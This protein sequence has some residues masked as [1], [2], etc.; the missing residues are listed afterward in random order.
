MGKK[1]VLNDSTRPPRRRLTLPNALAVACGIVLWLALIC[2]YAGPMTAA[3]IDCL[4]V[5]GGVVLLWLV[6]AVG[7]GS[8]ILP[9][10]LKSDAAPSNPLLRF[11]TAAAL[12]LGLMGLLVL[13]LGLAGVLNQIAAFIVIALAALA[14][15]VKLWRTPTALQALRQWFREPAGWRWLLLLAVPLVAV[16]TLGNL[17]PPYVLWNP[18]EPHGYDVVEY[19]LQVPREWFEAGRIFPLHHNVFSFFPFNVEMHYLLAMHLRGGPWAGMYAAQLMHGVFILLTVLAVGGIAAG[20]HSD[21]ARSRTASVLA[22]LAMAGA[23]LIWQLG[24]IAYDEGGFL[25]FGALSIGWA[26]LASR[27]PQKRLGPMALAGVMAGLACG[28]KLTAVPEVL[29]AVAL[30]SMIV[31][32]ARRASMTRA[33]TAAVVFGICGLI[34][35]APWLV[36][37]GVWAGNPVFPELPELGHG[38]FSEVQVERWH[39]A[40]SPR[41]DQRSIAARLRAGWVEVAGNWQFGFLLVPLAIVGGGIGRREPAVWFLG[42]MLFL[43]SVFWLGFTHLQ[44]RFFVLAIPICALLVATLPPRAILGVVAIEVVAAIVLLNMQLLDGQRPEI[45]HGL[46]GTEDLSLMT[47]T[48]VNSVPATDKLILVGDARAF[49]YQRPM[50]KLG[51]KTIFDADTSSGDLIAAWAGPPAQGQWL[52]IDPGE[53]KRFAKTY[54]PFPPL[55]AEVLAHNEQYL[56]RR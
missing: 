28:A 23:P 45:I 14:A 4:I 46:L 32:I 29:V 33:V 13:G 8:W 34:C 16:M 43:L 39:H 25:L 18:Q 22:M 6:A 21:P 10:F 44:G 15:L 42:A 26:L 40:H 1:R 54:P 31:L 17:L 38:Y 27:D 53:L 2:M 55:P 48:A 35:F 47:P 5:D 52:L 41:P 9:L 50:A 30:V 11:A 36:R 3:A 19:H 49:V 24:A 7:A 37:T 51:Y 12:G 20:L 56:V